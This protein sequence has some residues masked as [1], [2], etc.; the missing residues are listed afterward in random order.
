MKKWKRYKLNNEKYKANW[1]ISQ[2]SYEIYKG[3]SRETK[4]VLVELFEEQQK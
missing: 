1:K 2:E 4:E 3:E